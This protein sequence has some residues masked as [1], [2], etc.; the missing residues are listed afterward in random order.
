MWKSDW[1]FKGIEEKIFDF[2][3]NKFIFPLEQSWTLFKKFRKRNEKHW[4]ELRLDLISNPLETIVSFE[5]EENRF[6]LLRDFLVRCYH[7]LT[8]ISMRNLKTFKI[9][10]NFKKLKIGNLNR[11]IVFEPQCGFLY[12]FNIF[13]SIYQIPISSI[14]VEMIHYW[15]N[16]QK[17]E[18]FS[19]GRVTSIDDF[20]NRLL[21]IV[22]EY[23]KNICLLEFERELDPQILISD[24]LVNNYI[25]QF[26]KSYGW[27]GEVNIRFSELKISRMKY[28]IPTDPEFDI[29]TFKQRCIIVIETKRRKWITHNEKDSITKFYTFFSIL[30]KYLINFQVIGIFLSTG[31]FYD[32]LEF[33]VVEPN[34]H[35]TSPDQFVEIVK[36]IIKKNCY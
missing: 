12:I 7:I 13:P 23:Q 6:E 1:D 27:K 2:A 10:D 15:E 8:K 4:K 24:I 36:G 16:N 29:F 18:R 26:F 34:F 22:P 20:L 3:R 11:L 31:N 9:G 35:I 30:K 5:T 28:T 14:S 33:N 17:V 19:I 21:L 32:C 25:L